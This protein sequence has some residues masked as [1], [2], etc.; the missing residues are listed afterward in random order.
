MAKTKKPTAFDVKMDAG[1]RQQLADDLCRDIQDAFNARSLVIADGGYID[2][3]DWFYEQGRS[4][5]NDLPFPGAADLTSYFIT[6]NVDALRARLMKAVFGVRP[7][8]FV[9]GWGPSAK[10]APYVEEFT[11]WQVRSSEL[12]NELAKTIHGALIEDAYILEVSEKVETRKITETL[13]VALAVHPDLGGPVF[14]PGPDGTP[15]P[16]LQMDAQGEP[17]PAQEGQAKA[18]VERTSTKTKRLGPQY[19]PISMKDFVFL[20][21]HAKSRKHL[22]GYAY[23]FWAR[24]P[25]LEEKADDGVY[26]ADA[27]KLLGDTSDRDAALVPQPVTDVGHQLGPAVEKELFQLSLKRDLDEDGREEFYIVTLSMRTRTILR[28]KKDAFAQKLGRGRCVPFV[29]FPRRDSVYGYSYAFCKL[30]TLAEEHTAVRNMKADRSALAT[31]AP[32]M[33]AQGGIWNADE[34]PFGVGRIIQVRDKNELTPFQVQDVPPSVID[35]ERALHMAKE[36]VG[37]LADSAVGVLSGERRTLGENKLVAGGSAVRVDEVLGHL[38]AAI[39]EVMEISHAIWIE[40]LKAEGSKGIEAPSSVINALKTRGN[41]YELQDGTFT[42]AQLAGEYHFEPYGS[43]DTADPQMRRQ[44]FDGF[45]VA[46]TKLAQAMPALGMMLQNPSVA[47]AVL[48]Q[49]LRSYD[50]RD[51]QPFLGAMDQMPTQP[52]PMPGQP[53]MGGPPGMPPPGGTGMPAGLPPQ[54]M[55]LLAQGAPPAPG[56]LHG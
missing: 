10:N 25:E 47:K 9:E 1:Q 2:L 26:D 11:D 21:G 4:A 24:V 51:R 5:P 14:E 41:E 37:G 50:V 3:A 40:T 23:R 29:F 15:R 22:W 52:P 6:E 43:D 54:L 56:G 53:P 31:N 38:H 7:F 42:A 48:E 17:V 18:T 55:A 34:Q 35:S 16:K 32:I 8:C 44:N 49:L 46:L 12:R 39:A 13:D 45:V 30:L 19:D 20:P 33:Q 28:L 27:V 36:R